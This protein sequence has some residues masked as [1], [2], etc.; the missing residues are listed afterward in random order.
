MSDEKTGTKHGEVKR[1]HDTPVEGN[2]VEK[3]DHK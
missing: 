1:E 2:P 3:K